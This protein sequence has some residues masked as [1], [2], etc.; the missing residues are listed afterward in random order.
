MSEIPIGRNVLLYGALYFLWPFASASFFDTLVKAHQGPQFL[1]R[2]TELYPSFAQLT[3]TAL[4]CGLYHFSRPSH[5]VERAH[6]PAPF[7]RALVPTSATVF[8]LWT[9]GTY[10]L[11]IDRHLMIV[12]F[13]KAVFA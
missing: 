6:Y 11:M 10:N 7:P 8:L 12:V 2:R 13:K 3:D 4:C 5:H 1:A 9:H